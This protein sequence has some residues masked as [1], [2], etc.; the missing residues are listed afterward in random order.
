M[1]GLNDR[2]AKIVI[3]NIFICMLLGICGNSLGLMI[4]SVFKDVRAAT[5]FMPLVMLPL[6]IFAG[7]LAN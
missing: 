5:G 6:V 2:S 3:T 7:F 1:V 4:G